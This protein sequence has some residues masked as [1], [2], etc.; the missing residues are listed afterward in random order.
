MQPNHELMLSVTNEIPQFVE[1]ANLLCFSFQFVM[2]D[3]KEDRMSW[4]VSSSNDHASS[5]G[6]QILPHIGREI[7]QGSD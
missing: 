4:R 2:C 7:E 5:L 3:N 1:T 6:S